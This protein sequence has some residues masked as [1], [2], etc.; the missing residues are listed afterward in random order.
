[1]RPVYQTIK[2]D[3]ANG[4]WGNCHQAAVASILERPLEEVMHFGEDGVDG[5]EFA[6]REKEWLRSQGY[7]IIWIAFTCP[8]DDVLAYLKVLDSDLYWILGGKS[9]TGCGH[10]VVGYKGEIV[11]D[12]S[13]KKSGIVGPMDDGAYFISF[14]VRKP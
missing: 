1:M 2:H 5:V 11:H 12:P 10:S 13:P 3:P 6:R 4:A 7:E 8:L 14:I 9:R